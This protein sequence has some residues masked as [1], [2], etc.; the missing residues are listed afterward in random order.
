MSLLAATT[1]AL[2][3]AASPG[4]TSLETKASG[5]AARIASTAGFLLGNA[6]RCGIQTDRLVRAGQ[7]IR[8]L[9]IAAAKGDKDQE[10]A[11]ARFAQFFLATALDNGDGTL[12]ASCQ[13]VT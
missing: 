5:D 8:E 10:D 3:L 12:V 7:L 6:H 11:T 9:I 2:L 1:A 4:T 13:T